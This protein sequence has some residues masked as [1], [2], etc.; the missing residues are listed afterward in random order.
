MVSK[1]CTALALMYVFKLLVLFYLN[2]CTSNLPLG[3]H[4]VLHYEL[5]GKILSYYFPFPVQRKLKI[6]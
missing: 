5:R 2:F 6:R 4:S 3:I 1:C